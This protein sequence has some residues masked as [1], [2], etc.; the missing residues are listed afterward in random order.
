[1]SELSLFIEISPYCC[2]LFLALL[3]LLVPAFTGRYFERKHLKEL[4]ER[5]RELKGSILV[6]NRKHPFIEG[7]VEARMYS[8]EVVIA[9]DRFK[10]WLARWRQLVGGK[11]GSLAPVVERARREALLRAAEKAS[12]DGFTELGNV[13]YNTA[14]LKWANPQ[15]KEL[16]ICVQVFGTAYS[17]K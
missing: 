5:E 15:A 14:S 4:D 6:H 7:N 16:L 13:R 3:F 2:L 12:S 8:G 17:P 9:A 11:I 10:T 1:M